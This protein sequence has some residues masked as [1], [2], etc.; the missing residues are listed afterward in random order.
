[1]PHDILADRAGCHKLEK[2][3]GTARGASPAGEPETPERV[4]PNPGARDPPVNVE[5][6]DAKSLFGFLDMGERA[7][8]DASGQPVVAVDGK[9]TPGSHSCSV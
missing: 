1:M 6:S 7:R 9:E 3:I 8:K 2:G 4:A 5:V